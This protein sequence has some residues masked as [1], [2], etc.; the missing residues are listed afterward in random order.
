MLQRRTAQQL[1]A[2]AYFAFAFYCLGF[3]PSAAVHYTGYLRIVMLILYFSAL[4]GGTY[5]F[6]RT[7]LRYRQPF[8]IEH[9]L[10][11]VGTAVLV[12]LI[13]AVFG[14]YLPDY[15]R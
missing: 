11:G 5:A 8:R 2:T 14:I 9:G 7:A 6:V 3:F 12:L 15:S 10:L 1:M 4:V 13:P